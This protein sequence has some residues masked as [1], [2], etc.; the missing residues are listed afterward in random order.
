MTSPGSA[1]F[2]RSLRADDAPSGRGAGGAAIMTKV[3]RTQK[4]AGERQR[5]ADRDLDE[6]LEETFPASDPPAATH[7][8]AGAPDRPAAKPSRPRTS[9][10]K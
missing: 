3:P 1:T 10:K 6:A 8:S 4:D 2:S 5:Q 7:M 9:P